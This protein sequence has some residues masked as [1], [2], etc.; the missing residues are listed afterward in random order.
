MK[1]KLTYRLR[2]AALAVVT[3]LT[4]LPAVASAE[5]NLELTEPKTNGQ[6]RVSVTLTAMGENGLPIFDLAP[7]QVEVTENGVVQDDVVVYP[8]YERPTPVDTVLALDASLTMRGEPLQQAKAAAIGFVD[9]MSGDD[10]TGVVSFGKS[11]KVEQPLTTD[12]TKLGEAINRLKVSPLTP[13]YDALVLAAEEADRTTNPRAVILMTDGANWKS[14]LTA[15]EALER[16]Q[17]IGVP[18][19]TVGFG[20][21]AATK[22]LERIAES[23]GGKYYT[24]LSGSQ[25]GEIFRQISRQ[26]HQDYRLSYKS[27]TVASEGDTV[28]VRVGVRRDDFNAE[29]TFSYE[30]APRESARTAGVPVPTGDL[31]VVS[32]AKPAQQTVVMPGGNLALPI[33]SALATFLLS[34]GA[35]L[36]GTP[37]RVQKRLEFYISAPDSMVTVR[38]RQSSLAVIMRPVVRVASSIMLRILPAKHQRQLAENLAAAGHPYRWR[39]AHL[40]T[41]KALAAVLPAVFILL[42]S[43]N[44]LIAGALFAFGFYLPNFWLAKKVTQR[45]SRILQQLPDALDLLTISVQAGLGFDAAIAEVTQKWDNEIAIEF[46]M[47]LSEMKLGKSRR[48]ALKSMARRIDLPEMKIFVGAIVQAEEIGMGISRALSIQAEQMRLRKRQ[49]AE[50]K[51]HKAVIKILLPMVF[52]IFPAI[53]VVLLGPAVPSIMETFASMGK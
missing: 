34:V 2:H 7:E 37:S 47:V 52:F 21:K 31:R 4:L 35:W 33:G 24:A 11:V 17:D 45:K 1:S 16:V 12:T 14:K 5:G 18:V 42:T 43:G 15:D 51:A 41:F 6:P 46:G 3:V 20:E 26:L 49:K 19:F 30:Y 29:Q 40:V 32:E 38:G 50:E 25:L 36:A 39:L 9:N 8:F 44:L 48:E 22:P 28:E 10:R 27:S 13:L 53:F 23:T